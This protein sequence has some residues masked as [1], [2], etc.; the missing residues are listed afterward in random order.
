MLIRAMWDADI[1]SGYKIPLLFF[2]LALIIHFA[3]IIMG[4][5][6]LS[7]MFLLVIFFVLIIKKG[8]PITHTII[9]FTVYTILISTIDLIA[10]YFISS[11]F[12]SSLS[13]LV[14]NFLPLVAFI[15]GNMFS[16]IKLNMKHF[17]LT[18]FFIGFLQSLMGVL[19]LYSNYVQVT[20]LNLFSNFDKYEEYF[21]ENN[22]RVLGSLGNPN[23]YGEFIGW[24]ILLIM[25]YYIPKYKRI[26]YRLIFSLT[27]CIS[28]YA[29]LLSQSRT[30]LIVL[31][32]GI[33]LIGSLFT[34]YK[35]FVFPI[36]VLASLW[37]FNYLD[38][39]LGNLRG[40]VNSA[41]SL[42]GRSEIWN[43]IINNY[44]VPLD[45]N[46]IYGYGS[47]YVSNY[48][49]E[50][51]SYYLQVMLEYGALGLGAYIL[52]ICLFFYKALK[53]R[54][55]FMKILLFT[56]LITILVSDLTSE[57]SAHIKLGT[58][59]YFLLGF[60]TTNPERL[61]SPK[62]CPG[63]VDTELVKGNIEKAV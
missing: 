57:F 6:Y 1:R 10:V 25:F 27:L 13:G 19:Q 48:I 23:Y 35:I 11:S 5:E 60:L 24:F 39:I 56:C 62:G 52:L 8:L 9:Y 20:T 58:F 44:V 54:N 15:V 50:P 4:K 36:A 32:A 17:D 16:A 7:S 55:R 33:F 14:Y 51:H 30:A 37:A 3:P 46:F 22:I 61:R 12:L 41:S 18:V 29:I 2:M 26:R 28:T 59:F 21:A 63:K 40:G 42:G 53:T 31:V 34:K 38:V 47:A 45:W 49:T 43:S